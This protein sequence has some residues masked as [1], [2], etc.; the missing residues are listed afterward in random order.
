ML[1]KKHISLHRVLMLTVVISIVLLAGCRDGG[2]GSD[3]RIDIAL[4]LAGDNRAELEKVLDHYRDDSEKL[5]A[6][7][8]LIANMPGHYS[9][10]DTA[11]LTRYYDRVDSALSRLTGAKRQIIADTINSIAG[12]MGIAHA[13]TIQ[14][15]RI[16]TAD[17]LI[18]NI[19]DAFDQWKNGNWARHLNYDQFCEYILPY[20]VVDLQPLDSWRTDF[21]EFHTDSLYELDYCDMFRN[22]AYSAA[23]IMNR[24]LGDIVKPFSWGA[25]DCP[26]YRASTLCHIPFGYCDDY[27]YL[28][29]VLF[30]S[31]G[32][33]TS[34]EVNPHWAYR[35]LGHRANSV[36]A[37]NG[38]NIIFS[39]L[40]TG[41]EK[42]HHIDERLAKM[43]R[44]TYAH[45][46]DIIKLNQSEEFVPVGF[47]NIFMK[48]VT[49]EFISTTNITMRINDMPDGYVFL[50]VYGDQ[51]WF[52]VDFGYINSHRLS[53]EKVG[54][55]IVYI[56][57]KYDSNGEPTT[58]TDPFYID[59]NGIYNF[60][61]PDQDNTTTAT[62]YRKYPVI[63][64][65]HKYARL[66][67]G[68]EFEAS[69]DPDFTVAT[70]VHT[71]P[72]GK[73]I[74]HEVLLPDSTPPFR[75]WRYIQRHR[76]AHCNMGEVYMYDQD[77]NQLC[78][79]VIGTEG[80]RTIYEGMTRE[81]LFDGDLLT[82]FNSP[83]PNGDW[84]GMDF[85]KPV[86]V[87]RILY[88]GRGDGNSVEPGDEYELYFWLNGG[89][90]SLGRKKAQSV[91]VTFDNIPAGAL[92][93]LRDHTKGKDERIFTLTEEGQ[94]IFH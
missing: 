59:S 63:E 76:N 13:Q 6:A 22:S 16:I 14:D 35:S 27:A 47:K 29:T 79:T 54:K 17:Y 19:D 38:K 36:L 84:A 30:R 73:A 49:D 86:K 1:I 45:N 39:G 3:S 25:L 52:P 67:N 33:P 26:I 56:V 71:I 37:P 62:L 32:I 85:G 51:T 92:L 31:V 46:T 75:Y 12:N 74:G 43:F 42:S 78:G 87:S 18:K 93:L 7:R 60:I 81:N 10:S 5:C 58:I 68:G 11:L 80:H 88:Y 24:N 64:Y 70:T 94:Q 15:V 40:S 72:D 90:R 77:N 66:I 82:S 2:N 55:N 8:F 44:V 20:K 21:R 57:L 53:F 69:D 28:T 41:P 89:W 4:R 83:N 9:Y 61:Y 65:V 50:A 23:V 91:S 48:D 34:I